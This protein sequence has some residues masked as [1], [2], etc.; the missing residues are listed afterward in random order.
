LGAIGFLAAVTLLGLGLGAASAG[1]SES[2][3]SWQP[4]TAFDHGQPLGGGAPINAVSCPT[5]SFC[6]MADQHGNVLTSH[7]PIG[8]WSAWTIT[9]ADAAST[10]TLG[11]GWDGALTLISCPSEALCAAAD[12]LGNVLS[13]TDPAG[14]AASCG[15]DAPEHAG[16]CVPRIFGA[17]RPLVPVCHLVCRDQRP[18]ADRHLD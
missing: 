16:G 13:S 11:G 2:P 15:A 5:T 3:L 8:G 18:S 1:A 7:D 6:A 10:Q 4:P 14:P 9:R 12:S 17:D